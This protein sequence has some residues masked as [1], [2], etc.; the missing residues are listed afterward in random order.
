VNVYCFLVEEK[1]AFF[2]FCRWKVGFSLLNLRTFNIGA[3]S[4]GSIFNSP[5]SALLS[6][7]GGRKRGGGLPSAN[8]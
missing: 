1:W 6:V 4:G 8:L 5:I 7:G 3:D 2:L